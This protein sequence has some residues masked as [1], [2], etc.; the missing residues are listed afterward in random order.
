MNRLGDNCQNVVSRYRRDH[1]PIGTRLF[2][3]L[4]YL[5]K[6]NVVNINRDDLASAVKRGGTQASDFR[7]TV[8]K[9]ANQNESN[10]T[11][12]YSNNTLGKQYEFLLEGIGNSIKTTF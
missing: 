10:W 5:H 6:Q 3:E 8:A 12:D 7:R 2:I 4:K 1:F 9:W 11:N